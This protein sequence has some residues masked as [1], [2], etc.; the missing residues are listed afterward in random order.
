MSEPPSK[1]TG[2]YHPAF[3]QNLI[4]HNIYPADHLFPDGS[5]TE[6]PANMDE[7]TAM[8]MEPLPASLTLTWNEF[9]QFKQVYRSS[10]KEQQAMYCMLNVLQGS[11][12]M[13]NSALVAGSSGA[14][15]TNLDH[16]TDGTLH[17]A[18]PDYFHGS[19]PESLDR[20][21]RFRLDHL[22]APSKQKDLVILPNFFLEAKGPKGNDEIAMLQATYDGALGA[23]AMHNLRG[24]KEPCSA[25]YDQKAYTIMF[26]SVAGCLNIYTTH[27]LEP[28]S[29]TNRPQY[30]TTLVAGFMMLSNIDQYRAAITAYRNAIKWAKSKRDEAI[31]LANDRSG[32]LSPQVLLHLDAEVKTEMDTSTDELSL[33][34]SSKNH[35][36]IEVQ[37]PK[38][39]VKVQRSIETC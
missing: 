22:I 2:V 29:P 5:L 10:R 12:D 8:L 20:A 3:M 32:M 39:R 30:I 19:P 17:A 28:R 6:P 7:I 25:A 1:T 16:L 24:F 15:F 4:D 21:V 13:L 11:E 38:R 27:L 35:G 31:Q 37:I 36:R 26:T 34:L 33:G 23:R 14:V 18:R 9:R